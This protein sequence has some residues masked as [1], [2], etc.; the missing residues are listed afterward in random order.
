MGNGDLK[1]TADD[2]IHILNDAV[3]NAIEAL[4]DRADSL[5]EQLRAAAEFTGE[6]FSVGSAD[7]AIVVDFEIAHNWPARSIFLGVDNGFAGR[8]V[9]LAHHLEQ[10]K[11]RA[12]VLINR[13][14]DDEPPP[15]S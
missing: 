6:R 10:G 12:L 9:Q 3:D 11:Y 15:S 1:L 13:V 7:A 4:Q 5:A 2:A 14:P 8:P